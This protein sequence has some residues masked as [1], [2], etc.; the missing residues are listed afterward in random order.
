MAYREK[1][2]WLGLI[3]MLIT[4]GPYF[5]WVKLTSPSLETP[6]LGL[7]AVYAGVAGAYAVISIVGY[8]MLRREAHPADERDLLIDRRASRVAY[9]ILMALMLYIGC[10]KPF[11][12]EGGWEIVNDT[13]AAVVVTEITR[14]AMTL[15]GYRRA[16]A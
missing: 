6:N 1:T 5:A 9:Y 7:M 15:M 2:A 14:C 10:Y 16:A 12:A 11:V 13:I 4:F 8:L 3:G